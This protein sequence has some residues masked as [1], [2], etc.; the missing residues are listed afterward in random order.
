MNISQWAL[1]H[2]VPYSALIDLQ[3][4]LG[5]LDPEPGV[6]GRSEAAVQAAV[7]VEASQRGMRVWRNNVGVLTDD[8]G[9]PIRYGLCNDTP[10]MNYALKSADLIGIDPTPIT[11][12]DVGQPR[13]QFVSLECKPEGWRYTGTPREE[14]QAAW[15][16][17]I[18]SLG[19]RARFV[20]RVGLLS[21]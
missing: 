19:G 18:V 6:P 1:K 10:K 17:L 9:V 8:R 4:M 21:D 16:A 12:A 3:Q 11:L 13:G 7:R 15:A 20:N 2:G 14:A 5:V